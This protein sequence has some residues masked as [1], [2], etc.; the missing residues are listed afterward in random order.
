M[1]INLAKCRD[2]GIGVIS[3]RHRGEKV[4][5]SSGLDTQDETAQEIVVHVPEDV[6]LVGSSFFLGL[7]GPTI[8][9][10]GEKGF[11]DKVRF[12]GPVNDRIVD[13]V[14]QEALKRGNPLAEA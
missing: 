3:G 5:E 4:R 1:K 11:R 12:E 8:R 2:D 10:L 14:I 6:Y 9:R 7:L 13:D